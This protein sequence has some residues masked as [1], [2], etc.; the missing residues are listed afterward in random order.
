MALFMVIERFIG[1]DAR[2]I[3]QRLQEK[4]RMMPENIKYV[5][6]WIADDMSHCYQVMEAELAADFQPWMD[7]WSDLMEFS[8]VPVVTSAEAAARA[9]SK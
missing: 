6:S 7:E 8:V 5:G 1:G 3:Y 4:G 2:A 9:T